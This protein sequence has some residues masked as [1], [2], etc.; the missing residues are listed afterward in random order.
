MTDYGKRIR[1]KLDVVSLTK[2]DFNQIIKDRLDFGF[3]SIYFRYAEL[4]DE[5]AFYKAKVEHG[6]PVKEHK[7]ISWRKM[8]FYNALEQLLHAHEEEKQKYDSNSKPM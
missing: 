8:H 3:D 2:E 1:E 4:C 7:N 6:D 5:L